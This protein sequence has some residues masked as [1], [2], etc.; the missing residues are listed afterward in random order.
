[1]NANKPILFLTGQNGMLGQYLTEF[2]SDQYQVVG[3][4]RDGQSPSRPRWNYADQLKQLGIDTPQ[5]VIHLAGAGIA[6]KRWSDHYKQ[7][8][9]DSRTAGTQWLVNE[10]LQHE[11][12]PQTFLCASAIGYYGHRPKETLIEQSI[13]GNNFVAQV[14]AHWEHACQPLQ[15][16]EVRLA[17]LRFGMIL[18]P[19][20]GA[21]KDML[22]P[23]KL[24]LGGRLGGGQQMYSWIAIED[25]AR[26]IQ[27][28]LQDASLSGP[29]N[30]T[31]P[32]AVSNQTF[33]QT[34]AQT[35][36]RPAFMHMPA[37]L[38]RLIFGEVA[39]ELLL[40]DAQ[41]VPERLIQ[42]GFEFTHPQLPAA[43]AAMLA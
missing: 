4:Q 11:A 20:G 31:A 8:I 29:I 27:F 39:D 7:V 5:A 41:V 43:M 3:L 10:I 38:V 2:L 14:A 1:M 37:F 32:T 34:L 28:I 33:T 13:M 22:L 36:H 19:T 42:A 15:N 17:N 35:L 30:L 9:S 6:D 12:R 40:A 18:S 21:L 25:A 24:G 16:S 26:A 23:F